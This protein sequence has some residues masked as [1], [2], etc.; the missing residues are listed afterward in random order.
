[1]SELNCVSY[2][3]YSD[4]PSTD[5]LGLQTKIIFSEDCYLRLLQMISKTNTSNNETGAFFVGRKSK[6]DPFTILIDYSTSEFACVAAYVSGGGTA[7]QATNYSELNQQI[8]KYRMIDE[9]PVVIHFHTHPRKLYYES[10]SDRDL[11]M[12]VKMQLDNPNI[13]ALG[14]LGFPIPNGNLTNGFSIVQPV[15]PQINGEIG[16]AEFYMY[17]NIYYCTGNEIYKVGQF[18]KKY[19]GRIFCQDLGLKIVKNANRTIKPKKVCGVGLDPNTGQKIEDESVGYIDV[20]NALNFPDENL[21][22]HFSD[23]T[24]RYLGGIYK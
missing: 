6:E 5:D 2:D 15:R 1:M 13:I 19:V 18:D 17:P 21:T 22:F 10:F 14:M 11:S 7:P 16:S 24:L 8:S 3:Q 23:L 4:I 12:Y 20:N 9:K